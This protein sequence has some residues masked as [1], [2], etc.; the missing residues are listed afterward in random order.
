MSTQDPNL[1]VLE[2]AC[3]V[4]RNMEIQTQ[5]YQ[6]VSV[7]YAEM[8]AD[9]LRSI[10]RMAGNLHTICEFTIVDRAIKICTE[11]GFTVKAK[12]PASVPA[13]QD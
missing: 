5:N 10:V 7:K 13:P 8:Y 6:T 3:I 2:E 11:A 1:K 4:L 9:T 12:V